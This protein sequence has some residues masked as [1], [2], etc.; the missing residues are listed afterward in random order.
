MRKQHPPGGAGRSKPRTNRPAA[1]RNAVGGGGRPRTPRPPADRAAS[2]APAPV[3][4][5]QG[6]SPAASAAA[7]RGGFDRNVW[8][9]GR[10]AVAAALA[11][12]ARRCRRLLALPDTAA[13]LQAL[14]TK[15]AAK[16]TR[17]AE[18]RTVTREELAALLPPGAVHQG[19]AL[20]AD[21]LPAADIEDVIDRAAAGAARALVVVL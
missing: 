1:D 13:E 10:H 9:Y 21:P 16:L 7:D 20:A 3:A 12:P 19:L 2:A 11:N 4:H 14:L 15:A 6:R 8:I 5:G 17:D 18:V